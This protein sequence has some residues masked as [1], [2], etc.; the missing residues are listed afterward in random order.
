MHRVFLHTEYFLSFQNLLQ[1]IEKYFAVG[2]II[3]QLSSSGKACVISENRMVFCYSF[4]GITFVYT[5]VIKDSYK[6]IDLKISLF[7]QAFLDLQEVLF[8][9][10]FSFSNLN[11]IV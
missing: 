3:L 4:G 8:R 11:I 5:F 10:D 6:I 9:A 2:T 7:F 1:N